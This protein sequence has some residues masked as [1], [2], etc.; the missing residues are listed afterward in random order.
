M[1]SSSRHRRIAGAQQR[2]LSLPQA[3]DLVLLA[4]LCVLALLALRSTY[5][6]TVRVRVALRGRAVA[7]ALPARL[8]GR[9]PVDHPRRVGRCLAGPRGARCIRDRPGA[10]T[11]RSEPPGLAAQLLAPAVRRAAIPEPAR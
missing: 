3:G 5:G 1:S 9:R 7:P 11:R 2:V 4:G 10:S 6:G 8:A